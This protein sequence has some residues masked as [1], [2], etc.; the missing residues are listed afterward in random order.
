MTVLERVFIGQ[1][2]VFL[3]L[4]FVLFFFFFLGQCEVC[5]FVLILYFFFFF[6]FSF[7]STE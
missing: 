7:C 2:E 4:D 5:L 6:F 3:C 1:C